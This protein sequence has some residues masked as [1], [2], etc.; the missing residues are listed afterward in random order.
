MDT[1]HIVAFLMIYVLMGILTYKLLRF[2][3]I[4]TLDFAN[5]EDREILEDEKTMFFATSLVASFWII[6]IP[7]LFVS[8]ALN[9]FKNNVE[10]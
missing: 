3:I 1:V 8:S 2:M 5:K 10:D 6:Y 9:K 4:S 7:Y